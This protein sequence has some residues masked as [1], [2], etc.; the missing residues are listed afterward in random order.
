MDKGSKHTNTIYPVKKTNFRNVAEKVSRNRIKFETEKKLTIDP[1]IRD[2][3]RNMEN[4]LDSYWKHTER[5]RERT[6]K[7]FKINPFG[8]SVVFQKI[9]G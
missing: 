9:V 1:V 2:M 3:M 4:P 8:S 5:I 7:H 6:E